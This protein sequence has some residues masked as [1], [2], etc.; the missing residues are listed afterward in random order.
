MI[1][2][3]GY[4]QQEIINN[5]LA[6]HNRGRSIDFDP[7]YNAGGFYRNGAVVGPRVKS[8]VEPSV[9][10]VLK[11]DVRDLPFAASSF[12]SAIFDPPFL[13]AERASGQCKMCRKYGSFGSLEELREFY[14]QSLISLR[15]VLKHGGLLIFKCQD[16]V[17]ARSQNLILPYVC[18]LARELNF[19]CRDLFILLS[20]RRIENKIK[21]QQHARKYHCYFLVL[22]NNKRTP[23]VKGAIENGN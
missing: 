19:S 14:R 6:L 13:V 23:R 11:L 1:K 5:I 3:I 16:F 4:S 17:H 12:K 21:Q 7:C 20:N 2:S 9:S 15:R 8:D 18:G 22:K 10:G